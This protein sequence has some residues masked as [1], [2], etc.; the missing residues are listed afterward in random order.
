MTR[1]RKATWGDA[2]ERTVGWGAKWNE[3]KWTAGN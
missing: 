1:S 3:M 2:A